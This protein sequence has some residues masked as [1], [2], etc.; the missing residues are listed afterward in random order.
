MWISN[1]LM[2]HNIL[3]ILSQKT[4]SFDRYLILNI[5]YETSRDTGWQSVPQSMRERQRERENGCCKLHSEEPGAVAKL[6][7]RN[8]KSV[9]LFQ[10]YP[11]SASH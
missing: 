9:H 8:T 5:K 6:I 11:V 3:F 10:Q 4:F 2:Q 1:I 7:H